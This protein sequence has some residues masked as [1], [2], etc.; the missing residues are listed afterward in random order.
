MDNQTLTCFNQSGVQPENVLH[1]G[2]YRGDEFTLY[3]TLG[4]KDVIWVEANPVMYAELV[5]NLKANCRHL[6]NFTVDRAIYSESDKELEFNILSDVGGHN[7]G[8]SSLFKPGKFKELYPGI[9][10]TGAIKVKTVTVDDIVKKYAKPVQLLTMDLQGGELEA[11]KGS[12]NT[13]NLPDL[14]WIFTEIQIQP[15]YENTPTS[16]DLDAFLAKYSFKQVARC[17]YHELWGDALYARG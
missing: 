14:K 15:L 3:E 8:C 16:Q 13:L 2:A 11:L 4:V 1:L 9:P 7:R 10:Q 6:Q 17:M 12:T 5:D